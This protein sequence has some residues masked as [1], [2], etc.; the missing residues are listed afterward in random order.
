MISYLNSFFEK[1]DYPEDCRVAL[2]EAYD[3]L[4]KN[5]ETQG[6]IENSKKA[7][8]IDLNC[9]FDA[10]FNEA[11]DVAQKSSVHEFTVKLLLLICLSEEMKKYYDQMGYSTELYDSTI[12]DLKYKMIE[13]KLIKGIYGTFVPSWMVGF[14]NLTRFGFKRLQF[15]IRTAKV[16]YK[17]TYCAIKADDPV[18][19]VHIPRTGTPLDPI[20]CESDFKTAKEFFKEHFTNTKTAFAC[21]SWLLFEK[22]KD[23]LRDTSNI[24]A[25]MNNFDI[26][27]TDYL[28]LGDYS[29][30]WRLYDVD[31]NGN[32]DDLPEN[33]SLRRAFK[34]YLKEGGK[35]GAGYGIF[36]L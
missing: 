28:E 3:I 15:E 4:T 21:H 8:S 6:F 31:Y 12:L 27:Y 13:C 36:F 19:N 11:E 29:Q 17:N 2:L 33:S 35:W 25:F 20:E 7:Y 34:Q 14:F 26:I 18:I 9:N 23:F 10:F 24:V 5:S 22:L 16:D 1:Y 32:L 30:V